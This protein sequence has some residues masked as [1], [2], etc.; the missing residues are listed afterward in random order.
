M[1]TITGVR[2]DE[3]ILHILDPPDPSSATDK[4]P[5]RGLILSQTP[6]PKER[7]DP[8][9]LDYFRDHIAR[10]LENDYVRAACRRRARRW[11]AFSSA[12]SSARSW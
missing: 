11:R 1:A 3:V 6:L 8:R 9:V 2:V 12:T 7:T 10:A 4:P 5:R